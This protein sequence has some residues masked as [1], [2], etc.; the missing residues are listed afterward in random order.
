MRLAFYSG[1]NPRY[2]GSRVPL[3]SCIKSLPGNKS[4]RIKRFEDAVIPSK[5]KYLRVV[6][7]TRRPDNIPSRQAP[8]Q[9]AVWRRSQTF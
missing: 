5:A 4:R 7:H 1:F 9:S 8:P 2:T 6:L 3:Q